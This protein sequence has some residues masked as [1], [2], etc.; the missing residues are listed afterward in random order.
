[1]CLV[2]SVRSPVLGPLGRGS[3]PHTGAGC[4]PNFVHFVGMERVQGDLGFISTHFDGGDLICW[5]QGNTAENRDFPAKG[6]YS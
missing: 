1:M 4:D 5:N 3:I 2:V 6:K